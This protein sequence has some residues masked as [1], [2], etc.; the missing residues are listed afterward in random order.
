MSRCFICIVQRQNGT[1]HGMSLLCSCHRAWMKRHLE[2]G[3]DAVTAALSNSVRLACTNMQ[4]ESVVLFALALI[5]EGYETSRSLNLS[6][7]RVA[8]RLRRRCGLT[9][10]ARV[11]AVM[12]SSSGCLHTRK[13]QLKG[14][15]LCRGT[16]AA[17]REALGARLPAVLVATISAYALAGLVSGEKNCAEMCLQR[18][19]FFLPIKANEHGA[20]YKHRVCVHPRRSC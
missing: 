7:I 3:H 12:L 15:H 11:C 20:K 18:A 2:K 14:C 1:S 19:A 16:E 17:L 4:K 8:R 9:L 5:A 10:P 6:L 13:G